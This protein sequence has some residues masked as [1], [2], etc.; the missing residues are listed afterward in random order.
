MATH[1]IH[2]TDIIEPDALDSFLEQGWRPTGQS[3]YTS[4][5]LRTDDDELHG[6]LQIRLP[7]EGFTFKKRHRKLLRRN[8]RRFRVAWEH[9]GLPDRE[10]LRVNRR[11]MKLHAHKS[12]ED[13]EYNVINELGRKILDTRLCRIYDG[14]RLA[15][16]SYFDVGH[17]VMYTKAGIYDPDYA[18]DSLGLFTMLLEVERAVGMGFTHYYPGYYS[19]SYP[20]FDYKLQLGPMEYRDISTDRWRKHR[21]DGGRRPVD[22]LVLNREQLIRLQQALHA[23]AI[24]AEFREY[25]SFTGRFRPTKQT[26]NLML[27]APQL[28]L[29]GRPLPLEYY[30]VITFDNEAGEYRYDIVRT[31][32]LYDMRVQILSKSGR[33]RFTTPVIVHDRLLQTADVGELVRKVSERAFMF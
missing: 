13:L 14:E 16:F 4:D 8:R 3:I 7:L 12:R 17:R 31:A 24:R 26:D 11:Y 33:P 32:N 1:I 25:P 18:G 6:C 29:I 19:P 15:A 30:F 28:L 9:A 10:L 21:R 20:A 22:P 2:P 5:Y 23:R 27:D